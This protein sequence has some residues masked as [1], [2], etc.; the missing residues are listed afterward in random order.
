MQRGKTGEGYV[1]YRS[2]ARGEDVTVYEH[3]LM[4][5]LDHDPVRVFDEST[6]VHHV[7]SHPEFN[8]PW[9]LAVVNGDEH[10]TPIPDRSPMA[11]VV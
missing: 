9:N 6:E 11:E 8:V 7:R 2:R 4:A 10:R 1:Y 5:L 3:Q